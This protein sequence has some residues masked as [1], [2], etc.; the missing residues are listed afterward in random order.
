MWILP[1]VGLV[2]TAAGLTVAFRALAAMG[3]LSSPS[4][5]GGP[6]KAAG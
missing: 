4:A 1:V 2:A 3:D 5:G 6:A